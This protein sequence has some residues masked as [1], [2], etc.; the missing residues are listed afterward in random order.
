MVKGKSVTRQMVE[1][2]QGKVLHFV[3]HDKKLKGRTLG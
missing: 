2:S 1:V 3:L